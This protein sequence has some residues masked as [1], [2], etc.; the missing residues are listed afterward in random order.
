MDHPESKFRDSHK[1]GKLHRRTVKVKKICYIGKESNN[2]EHTE[3][4][5]VDKDSYT[6]Y[7]LRI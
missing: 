1:I 3:V 7:H 2:L 6:S 4:L 5:G